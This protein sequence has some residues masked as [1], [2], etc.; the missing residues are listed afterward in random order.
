MDFSPEL[1]KK[2]QS[3][4][5]RRFA[6]KLNSEEGQEIL[7]TLAQLGD[8]FS[9]NADKLLEKRGDEKNE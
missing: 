4:F 6:K 3:L 5:E 2:T 1:V 8:L 9:R 7:S